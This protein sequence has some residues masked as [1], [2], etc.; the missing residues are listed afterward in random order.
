MDNGANGANGNSDADE[1]QV[2]GETDV[3]AAERS[4]M[5]AAKLARLVE[6]ETREAAR[7]GGPAPSPRSI[8]DR[9][10]ALAGRKVISKDTVRILLTGRKPTGEPTNPTVDTLDWL[11]KGFG[12]KSGAA[13]FLDDAITERV[14]AQ[15]DQVSS[16]GTLTREGVTLAMRASGLSADHMTV[17]D[18]LV[19][20]LQEIEA[21][22]RDR[23]R[24][25]EGSSGS[26]AE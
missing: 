17:V 7:R 14:D 5:I 11:A 23:V 16:L 8:A 13:Y 26:E 22:A 9:I 15:L 24:G 4:R 20:R 6:R 1:T 10:C 18:A 25:P 3:A 12:I 2:A 19:T 21:G